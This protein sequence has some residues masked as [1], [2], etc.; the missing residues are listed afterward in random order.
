VKVKSITTDRNRNQRLKVFTENHEVSK[1][2]QQFADQVE[3]NNIIKKYQKTG[4]WLHVTS[5]TGI[6][7]DV[8]QIGDYA[9]CLQKVL[10]ANSAFSSLPSNIRARFSN[11]PA[12]LLSFLQDPSNK[13]EAE[14]LGLLNKPSMSNLSN[15]NDLNES[16]KEKDKSDKKEKP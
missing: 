16:D 10:D 11:D 12:Q 15:A 14:K 8:S 4:Q 3:I 13:E 1:T 9:Q 2:Q 7:A 6:Y 5:K